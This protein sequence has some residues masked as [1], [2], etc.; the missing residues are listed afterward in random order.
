MQIIELKQ[1]DKLQ[2]KYFTIA[3]YQA[4]EKGITTNRIFASKLVDGTAVFNKSSRPVHRIT[5]VG[6][7]TKPLMNAAT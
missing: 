2:L 6:D 5:P 4:G 1:V 3:V 7:G